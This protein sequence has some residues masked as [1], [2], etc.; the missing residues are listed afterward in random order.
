MRPKFVGVV[1][2]GPAEAVTIAARGE[3]AKIIFGEKLAL[4][5]LADLAADH[6]GDVQAVPDRGE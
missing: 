5:N 2:D 6:G 1:F 4:G 3:S